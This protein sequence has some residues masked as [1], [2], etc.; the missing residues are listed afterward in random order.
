MTNLVGVAADPA[1]VKVGMPVEVAYEAV[2]DEV[3]LP[4]FRPKTR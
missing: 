2:T 4:K 1:V 3:T